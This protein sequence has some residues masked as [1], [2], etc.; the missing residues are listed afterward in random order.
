MSVPST[1][2]CRAYEAECATNFTLFLL[3]MSAWFSGLKV[4]ER[5]CSPVIALLATV[6]RRNTPSTGLGQ[7]V[8]ALS[9][10][11]KPSPVRICR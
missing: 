4:G 10:P 11:K 9:C 3:P 6:T 2:Y 5:G 1:A 7:P 8:I